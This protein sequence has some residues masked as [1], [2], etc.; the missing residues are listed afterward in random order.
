MPK[1]GRKTHF[2]TIADIPTKDAPRIQSYFLDFA[3]L[4]FNFALAFF[5][6]FNFLTLTL[7]M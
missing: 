5:A 6:R 2:G 7:T 3:A 4:R 1:E